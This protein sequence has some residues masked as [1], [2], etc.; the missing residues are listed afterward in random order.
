MLTTTH[1]ILS[2][3]KLLNLFCEHPFV[4]Y[5][6]R[7]PVETITLAEISEIDHKILFILLWG[8]MYVCMCKFLARD[9]L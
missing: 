3:H 7:K 6:L 1:K 9:Y 2:N 5:L 4:I 8:C